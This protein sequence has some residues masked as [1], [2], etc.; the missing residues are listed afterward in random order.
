MQL[1]SGSYAVAEDGGEV[2]LVIERVGGTD[3]VATVDFVTGGGSATAGV[4]FVR[5]AGTVQFRPG[6]ATAIVT[7]TLVDDAAFEG[8][9]SFAVS[10]DRVTGAGLGAPRTALVTIADDES[11]PPAPSGPLP[12]LEDFALPDGADGDDGPTAWAT[13]AAG[14][15]PN[16][17]F[18]V[19]SGAL[20]MRNPDAVVSWASEP[21]DVSGVAAAGVSLVWRSVGNM[22]TSGGAHDWIELTARLDGGEAVVLARRDGNFNADLPE[23]LAFDGLVGDSLVIGVRGVTTGGSERYVVDDVAAYADA[24]PG[25]SGDELRFYAQAEAGGGAGA[26]DSVPSGASGGA[27]LVWTGADSTAEP[28]AAGLT[29]DFVAP[30]D[31]LYAVHLRA[32]A[33]G[34]GDDSVWVRLDDADVAASKR[35][36]RADGWVKFNGI[37]EGAL[38]RWD[39]VHNADDDYAAVR[40][41]LDAGP[42]TLRIAPRENGTELDGVYVTNTADA[43]DTL[44]LDALGGA[45]TGDAT[46][47]AVPVAEGL[48]K[49]TEIVPVPGTA[50]TFLVGEQDGRIRV[51]K[52]GQVLDS[53]FADLSPLDER[54]A[55]PG[56]AG[57]GG[58]P[59]SGR[60]GRT[61][62]PCTPTTRPRTAGQG[63]LAGP[64]R[65]G[66][67]AGRVV[68]LT[69]PRRR[70]VPRRRGGARGRSSW[71]GT[72]PGPTSAGPTATR[73]AT[74]PSPPAARPRAAGTSTTSSPPIPRATASATCSSATTAA[75]SSPSATPRATAWSTPRSKYVQD[76]NTL[77]GKLLRIDPDTGLGLPGKP[78]STP[79]TPA[80]TPAASGRWACGTRS[81]SPSGPATATCSSATWGGTATRRSTSSMPAARAGRTSA[82]RG[83]RA[84][85][86][87]RAARPATSGPR[88]PPTSTP[89]A[90]ARGR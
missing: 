53:D 29:F 68:R 62:T 46:F 16:G 47:K 35:V 11:P 66:N 39:R 19:D 63:G 58:G 28:G 21:I 74:P 78:V 64:D 24:N 40:F 22:E 54:D 20:V 50:D 87:S 3:G 48:G 73:P 2:E 23:S 18:A 52:G 43:P 59:P 9:E 71:A 85:A 49:L 44:R 86:A 37:E 70:R 67:R 33:A 12:W 6:Q 77:R 88:T 41:R 69:A 26:W 51:M 57:A 61:S 25:V 30:A 65:N 55:G 72:A 27:H 17:S 42:H 31:G 79:A 89:A 83:T 8:D 10:L 75:S 34:G 7:I 76:L 82:G 90:T 38:F 1:R 81:A 80:P 4:D 32:R 36:T 56:A 13:R 84:R 14:I 60:S 15:N 5:R 45:G